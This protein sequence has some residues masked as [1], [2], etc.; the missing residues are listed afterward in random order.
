MREG[1]DRQTT[2][3]REGEE[4]PTRDIDNVNER[5]T[6]KLPMSRERVRHRK[7]QCYRDIENEKR[8]I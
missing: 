5:E 2:R 7:G 3:M 6:D 8:C 4:W 1:E